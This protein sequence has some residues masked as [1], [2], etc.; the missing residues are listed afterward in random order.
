VV[1]GFLFAHLNKIK[2]EHMSFT[3]KLILHLGV[4]LGGAVVLA[5][6]DEWSGGTGSA[7]P[8]RLAA[9]LGWSIWGAIICS[10]PRLW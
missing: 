7:S 10:L 9:M 1:S 2:G 8:K 3:E 6:I 5:I 4:I